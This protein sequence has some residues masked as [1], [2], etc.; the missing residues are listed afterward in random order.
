MLINWLSCLQMTR[1]I[2]AELL[3]AAGIAKAGAQ[4]LRKIF[5]ISTFSKT[6]AAHN[7]I[8]YMLV[9]KELQNACII[10]VSKESKCA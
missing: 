6:K 3:W 5:R 4:A 10:L 8:G 1:T 9:E 7:T 2:R